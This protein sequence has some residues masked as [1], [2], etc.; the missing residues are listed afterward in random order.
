VQLQAQEPERLMPSTGIAAA[1]PFCSAMV[2]GVGSTV[3]I[4]LV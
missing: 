4:G 1:A 3:L 2:A